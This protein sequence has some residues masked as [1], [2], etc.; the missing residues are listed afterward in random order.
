MALYP[1]ENMY[2]QIVVLVG[3]YHPDIHTIIRRRIKFGEVKNLEQ[4]VTIRTLAV[5]VLAASIR[6]PTSAIRK[7]LLLVYT[8]YFEL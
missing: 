8:L 3:A 6:G 1:T 5:V 2:Y 7:S 4:R